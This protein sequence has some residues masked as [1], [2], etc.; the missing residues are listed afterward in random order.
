MRA[1]KSQSIRHWARMGI[2]CA[3]AMILSYV[4]VL[5][6]IPLPVP[7]VKLG[8]ANLVIIFLLYRYGAFEAALVSLARLLLSALLFGSAVSLL[9]AFSGALCSFLLMLLLK[10]IRFF[11]IVGV[12]I[13]GGVT[14]NLAQ[15]AMAALVMKTAGL[16]GYAPV[17]CLC[18][19]LAGAVIGLLGAL[20]VAKLP[21]YF[22]KPEK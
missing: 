9:Y 7:G 18:G 1:G 13:A 5:L 22:S 4:E 16:A 10:R 2:F 19:T 17:L 15:I 3:L 21:A 8:L 20:L 12:S 11:S 6:P 14:H